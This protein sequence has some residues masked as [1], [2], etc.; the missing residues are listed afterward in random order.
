MK[1][2]MKWIWS[3]LCVL[4]LTACSNAA[5][6]ANNQPT[7]EP[8]ETAT[9]ETMPETTDDAIMDEQRTTLVVYFSATGNT[10]EVATMIQ[11]A[12]NADIFE[13]EVVE[14]YSSADLN[15]SNEE[16]RV[17]YEHENPQAQEVELVNTT[18]ENWDDYDTVFIG[19]PIWWQ[20]AAWPVHG[21]I[22]ANDFTNKTVI[23]FSTSAS[24]GFGNSGTLLRDLAGT[25][26]W[27]EGERFSSNATLESIQ[28]WLDSLGL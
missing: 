26:E 23:P 1:K 8:T 28:E 14:P 20:A 18:V 12:M 9:P 13:L 17:V 6:A 24:S 27:L 16:S 11:S 22:E 25:G 7:T 2:T 4:G 3:V 5:P 15:Y 21:F 19:Y 10:E